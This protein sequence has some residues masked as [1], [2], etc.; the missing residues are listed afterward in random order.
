MNLFLIVFNI[1]TNGS[2]YQIKNK[3]DRKFIKN[4][5]KVI[6]KWTILTKIDH[7]QQGV[8][9]QHNVQK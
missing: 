9:L 7:F 4:F 2:S 8:H 1:G 5:L 6:W 3:N